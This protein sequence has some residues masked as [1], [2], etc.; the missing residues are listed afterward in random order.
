VLYSHSC[1]NYLTTWSRVLP[2]KWLVL[3]WSRNFLHFT[4]PDA[5]SLYSQEPPTCHYPEPRSPICAITSYFKIHFYITCH[6]VS[7]FH[8][9]LQKPFTFSSHM[10]APQLWGSIKFLMSYTKVASSVTWE[11]KPADWSYIHKEWTHFLQYEVTFWCF[12]QTKNSLPRLTH[13]ET[14]FS[15]GL[16]RLL[17]TCLLSE[18][19]LLPYSASWLIV[20]GLRGE[21]AVEL[22]GRK[23]LNSVIHDNLLDAV[24]RVFFLVR[25]YV[26]TLFTDI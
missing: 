24:R 13:L 4:E 2:E 26:A 23:V 18:T 14:L 17:I 10:F 20:A 1:K 12:G 21:P 15:S 25:Q 16:C 8:V 11:S 9:F 22:L 3:S 7:F 19:E 5:S 6:S